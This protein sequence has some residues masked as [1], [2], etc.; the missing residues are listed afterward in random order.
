MTGNTPPLE[1]SPAAER[2]QRSR[3]QR[4]KGLRCVSVEISTAEID[5][6]IEAGTLDRVAR[7][8][9]D[10]IGAALGKMLDRLPIQ[11]WRAH[12]GGANAVTLDLTDGFVEYLATLGWLPRRERHDS[13]IPVR[14][15]VRARMAPN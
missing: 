2:M 12:P 15:Y 9:P 6:L 14:A 13:S 8:D 1:R 7:N 10:A 11:M 5:A 3:G 4:R